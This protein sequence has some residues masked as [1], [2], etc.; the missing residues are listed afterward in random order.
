MVNGIGL[1]LIGWACCMLAFYLLY[2]VC[3]RNTTLY[4]FNRIYLIGVV[5]VSA[6]LPLIHLELETS[7]I[8]QTFS[9]LPPNGESY[10]QEVL[11]TEGETKPETSPYFFHGGEINASQKTSP[12]GG[13]KRGVPE[14]GSLS[15][16]SWLSILYLLYV[17]ISLG[18]YIIAMLR[19]RSLVA[20]YPSHRLGRWIRIVENDKVGIPFSW[21]NLI[22][23]SSKEQGLDR[24]AAIRHE[25][26][27]ITQLHHIDLLFFMLCTIINPVSWLILKEIRRVHEY[28]V[29]AKVV[30]Y[31]GINR[32]DYQ[33]LLLR[34]A[35]GQEAF[36]LACSFHLNIGKRIDMM[37]KKQSSSKRLWWLLLAIPLIG[38]ALFIFAVPAADANEKNP[39]GLYRLIKVS[40]DNK[41]SAENVSFEQYKY[42][43]KDV[44]LHLTV[45]DEGRRII[46][47]TQNDSVLFRYTGNTPQG[48]DGKDYQIYDVEDG[49]FTLKWYNKTIWDNGLFPYEEFI[50]EHYDAN[51]QIEPDVRR[52]VDLLGMRTKDKHEFVGCW[53][54]LAKVRDVNAVQSGLAAIRSKYGNRALRID[55]DYRDWYFIIDDNCYASVM[56]ASPFVT[57]QAIVV[58]ENFAYL[59]MTQFQTKDYIY[60]IE[61][62]DN[63]SFVASLYKIGTDEM[64]G[65]ELWHRTNLPANLGDVFM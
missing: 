41:R 65:K 2:M 47:I 49:R 16:W 48:V 55:S 35:V 52:I 9:T 29:D 21:M 25:L 20:G 11:T 7:L 10:Y 14:K 59:S 40:Y 64:I 33:M 6:I 58:L 4:R 18:W 36:A 38:I 15:V 28:E 57:P 50:N 61:W 27:H 43:G 34:R 8:Q 39:H 44:T 54:C 53:K 17:S 12:L 46:E 3:F 26:T 24:K 19:L 60:Q 22:V 30:H 32:R 13:D 42:C 45:R 31:Y 23:L 5:L 37:L 56:V 51:Q 62:E 1:Y 63:N